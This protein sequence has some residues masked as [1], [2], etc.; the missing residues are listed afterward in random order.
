MSI[1]SVFLSSIILALIFFIHPVRAF[2]ISPSKILLTID[3]NTS[4]TVVIK[5]NNSESKDLDF[6][7]GVLGLKQDDSGK[8]VLGGDLTDAENWVYPENKTI[9]IKAGQAKIAN[10]ILNVPDKTTPGSYYVGLFAESGG[11]VGA[12]IVSLL[13]IQ[14]AGVVN[15]SI[16][17]EKW[18]PVKNSASNRERKFEVNLKNNGDVEVQ[19]KSVL[20]VRNWKG[21]EIFAEP[22]ILGNKLLA[23]SRRVLSTSVVLKDNIKLPG[24]YQSQI[25]INFGLSNQMTSAIAYFWFFPQWSQVFLIIFG[26]LI[27]GLVI[28]VIKRKK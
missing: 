13:T 24:L 26:I 21:E 2:G 4:Q 17:I 6:K 15:E 19:L 22:L 20:S 23:G 28:F 1:R 8:P 11:E 14:V 7:L 9:S 16:L 18:L 25:K 3:P 5:I 10:F 12:R 27:F